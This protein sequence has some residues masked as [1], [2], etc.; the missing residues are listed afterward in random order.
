MTEPRKVVL[1][2]GN[3]FDLN[4]G[5]ETSYKNFWE[6]DYC[7]KDYPAPLINHMN[8]KW[9]DD[10]DAVKW[11]DLENELLNYYT[12]IPDPSK[13]IDYISAEEK[14]LLKKFSP[15]GYKCG[16]FNDQL[17]TLTSLINKHVLAYTPPPFEKIDESPFK[18]DCLQS[19]IMRDYKAL[20]LIKK[21]LCDYL[22]S[23]H[24]YRANATIAFQVINCL[25]HE[26]EIGHTVNIYTFNYTPVKLN[27]SE[28]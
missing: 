10:L 18:A 5:L 27:D 19:P 1:I 14:E 28:L 26:A 11:Y 9:K 4:L 24:L 3:G 12:S 13:G 8:Q 16:H 22:N 20:G 2:L 25:D 17:E 15:Y 23:L 7:P 21:G 6:S